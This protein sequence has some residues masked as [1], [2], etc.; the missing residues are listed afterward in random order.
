MSVKAKKHLGQHFLTDK[1]ICEKIAKQYQNDCKRVLE[2]GPGMGA[3]TSYLLNDGLDVWVMEIDT[4]SV[5]YL[6]E[7]FERLEGKI[8][9]KDFLKVNLTSVP[10]LPLISLTASVV[11]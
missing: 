1:N 10:K 7:V 3:L 11:S 5:D 6:K 9:E 4:E 2:I 8:L